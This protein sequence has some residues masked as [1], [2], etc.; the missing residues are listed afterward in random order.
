M[1]RLSRAFI[2]VG[3]VALL[4][5]CSAGDAGNATL[6]GTDDGGSQ[7]DSVVSRTDARIDTPRVDATVL[8]D[9][10]VIYP[11]VARRARPTGKQ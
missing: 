6:K 2:G 8:P 4:A 1:R 11:D 10:R 7:P 3:C 9:G 5:A